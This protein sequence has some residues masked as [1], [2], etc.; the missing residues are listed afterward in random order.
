MVER[1]RRRAEIDALDEEG[2]L[3]VRELS[4]A[5]GDVKVAYY[6]EGLL[7]VVGQIEPQ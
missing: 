6:S 5:M 2:L 7:R 4:S 3:L 1:V